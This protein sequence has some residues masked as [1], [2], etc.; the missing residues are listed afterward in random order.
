M[1]SNPWFRG[2]LD[3]WFPSR[4]V[5]TVLAKYLIHPSNAVWADVLD[6]L[7]ANAQP[8]LLSPLTIGLQIRDPL[9]SVEKALGCIGF[10]PLAA[11]PSLPTTTDT[12]KGAQVQVHVFIASLGNVGESVKRLFPDWTVSQK[13]YDGSQRNDADQV[14]KALHDIFLLSI[15]DRTVLSPRSTFGYMIM[16]LKG[17]ICVTAGG[18]DNPYGVNRQQCYW[19]NN[20]EI[21]EHFGLNILQQYNSSDRPFH[22]SQQFYNQTYSQTCRD[23]VGGVQLLTGRKNRFML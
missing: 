14:K 1:F 7:S 5:G 15:T 17:S 16:A 18:D 4:N 10:G 3:E 11:S 2:Q 21:C 9:R 13:Y 6:T 20:H 22:I 19:P 8:S 12:D 23:Y